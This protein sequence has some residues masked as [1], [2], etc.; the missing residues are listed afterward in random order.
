MIRNRIFGPYRWHLV[1]ADP[2]QHPG[3]PAA[4]VPQGAASRPAA[5][6]VISMF[7]NVGMWFERFVIIP[8]SLHRDFLPSA[9]GA[10][11]TRRRWDFATFFGTIGLFLALMFL[12]VRV[13]PAIAIFEMSAL[14]PDAKVKEPATRD[15]RP[16]PATA[17]PSIHG[18]LAEYSHGAGA[19]R[20]RRKRAHEAGYR[21]DGR[22]HAVPDRG[23]LRDHL[24]PP[25]LEGAA[26]LLRRRHRSAR[27]AASGSRT[28]PRRSTIR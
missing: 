13:L 28:G 5:L 8:M 23:A 1:H 3:D 25:P 19:A 9:R 2:V 16:R 24:R 10:C 27:S 18:L 22:L 15:A 7:V 14:T 17:C 4:L 26:D 11:T 6:F 20:R 12:F 21:D